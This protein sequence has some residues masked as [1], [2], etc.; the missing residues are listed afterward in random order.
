MKK[1]FSLF[2]VIVFLLVFAAGAFAQSSK[3]KTGA[4]PTFK[5]AWSHYV[6]WEPWEYA[7]HA[8]IIDKWAKKYGIKIVLSPP[9]TYVNSISQYVTGQYD[10]CVM[11]NMDALIS[12]AMGGIDSTA[13][14]MGDTSHGN[15]GVV[16]KD[17]K[18]FAELKGKSVFLAVGS[19][20]HYLLARGLDKAGMKERELKLLN[21]EED[22][23]ATVFQSDPKGIVVTWNP[24]LM[25]VRNMKGAKQIF[26]SSQIPGEIQDLMIVRTNTPDSL[27]KALVGAWFETMAILA[28]RDETGKKAIAYMAKFSAA[29]VAEFE[30]QV[31]TTNVF[32]TPKAAVDF[33]T[34]PKM[35]E[36]MELVR[37]FCFE[38]GLLE[39]AKSKDAVGIQFPNGK[40]LGDAKKVK[41]RFDATFMKLAAEG[42]L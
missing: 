23:I 13:L 36:I 4:T 7:R 27:K 16:T 9:L 17:E 30:A 3:S 42:K 33:T 39:G 22:K 1:V 25:E 34:S 20:S 28:K 31:K 19:V 35:E 5:V 2:L 11:T 41:L 40:I 38:R 32:Y 14:I 10:A 12:P 29:T 18:T 8:G 21:T 37:S 24:F 6:W 26:D 15:D